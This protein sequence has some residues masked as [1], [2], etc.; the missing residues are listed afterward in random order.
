[1]NIHLK[2]FPFE[3][4]QFF[5]DF[6]SNNDEHPWNINEKSFPFETFQFCNAF[7]SDNDEQL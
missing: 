4:F 6:I 1:M 3:T 5:N 7:K 2:L